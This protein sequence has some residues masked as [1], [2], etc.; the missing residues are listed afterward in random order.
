MLAD[1]AIVRLCM[2]F[3]YRRSNYTKINAPNER[4]LPKETEVLPEQVEKMIIAD[5]FTRIFNS[6][7]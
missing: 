6:M 3:G 1:F 2:L 5:N 7:K 4:F